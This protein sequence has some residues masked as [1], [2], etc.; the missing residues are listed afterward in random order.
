MVGIK[1]GQEVLACTDKGNLYR[2]KGP[3]TRSIVL[4]NSFDLNL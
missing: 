1:N 4:L 3:H 2:F